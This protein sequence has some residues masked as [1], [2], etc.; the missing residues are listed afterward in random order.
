MVEPLEKIY[1]GELL[2]TGYRS[3]SDESWSAEGERLVSEPH[4]RYKKMMLGF[5]SYVRGEKK[6]PYD[7]DYERN[8][9]RLV[10]KA[11][12]LEG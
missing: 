2:T 11:C 4:H 9:Y 6:N 5:A 1:E 3:T 12:G 7:Y 8:L 10:H